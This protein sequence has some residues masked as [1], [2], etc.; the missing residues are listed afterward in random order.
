MNKTRSLLFA[1][2]VAMITLQSCKDDEEPVFQI[3][4]PTLDATGYTGS[5]TIGLLYSIDNGVTYSATLP[6][7]LEEGTKVLVKANDGTEDLS[8]DDFIFDWSGSSPAPANATANVA[9]FT[10]GTS[11][12]SISLTLEE[13]WALLTSHRQNGKF[14]TINPSNGATTEVFTATF[15]GVNMKDFRG[16][17]YHPK[18]KLYYATVASTINDQQAGFLYTINPA[19]KVA[20]MINENDG[21][22]NEDQVLDYAIWDAVVNWSVAPDDSLIGIGDFNGDGNGIVKFG[23]DGGRSLKTVEVDF[24]CG[25]GM[26]WVDENTMLVANGWSTG[27][28]EVMLE[29]IELNGTVSDDLLI[30]TLEGFPT[31]ITINWIPVRSLAKAKDGTL[32]GLM[33]NYDLNLTYFVK[34]DMANEKVVYI[35]TIGGSAANQYTTL[36]FVPKHLL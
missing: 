31:D 1:F 12:L 17:V 11:N 32:Y 28:G 16:F 5:G 19:T 34:V 30:T 13:V 14:F 24:C 35:S 10:V 22:P 21:D 9:E 4:T 33:F 26:S 23:K 29:N 25:L 36:A 7:N 20:T 3:G 18:Q 6:A 27:D 15:E 2:A 8:A